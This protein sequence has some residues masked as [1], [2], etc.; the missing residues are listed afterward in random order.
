MEYSIKNLIDNYNIS[1]PQRHKNLSVFPVS[2]IQNNS[3]EFMALDTAIQKGFIKISEVSESGNVNALIVE[4]F[5]EY[6]VLMLDGEE[7]I[8]AKQNRVLNTSIFLGGRSK[9]QVPVSCVERGRWNY[10]SQNFETSDRIMSASIKSKKMEDVTLNLKMKMSND[11]SSNQGRVWN[12][13]DSLMN[14][15]KKKS[16]TSA[17]SDVF[18]SSA[19]EIKDYMQHFQLIENQN[20]MI[21]TI[22]GKF[23]G[24]EYISDKVV[25]SQYFP[26]ILRGFV[27][28]SLDEIV[29]NFEES[30]VENC[31]QY[32]NNLEKAK[33]S[34]FPSIGLG[35]SFRYEY[36]DSVAA[37]L[38]YSDNLIHISQLFRENM[39]SNEETNINN[40]LDRNSGIIRRA[41]K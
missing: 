20:G 23:R 41:K 17:M 22:N 28:D 1:E 26:K 15:R 10:K 7:L 2:F 14:R 40:I 24:F 39:N 4:N 38:V 16:V 18:E 21:I 25:F 12:E 37:A 29:E 6:N 8:G 36:V 35:N 31:K 27:I 5:S 9:T 30:D 33:Q 19:D 13:I 32:V 3:I 11:Y 34:F